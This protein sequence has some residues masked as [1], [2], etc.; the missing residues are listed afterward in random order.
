MK[1]IVTIQ[2]ISCIGKCSLTVALPILSAM[3]LETAILPTA[4]LS[5]HTMFQN[6]AFIDLTEQMT[7]ITDHWAKEGFDFE[8][9]YTGY[10]ASARQVELVCAFLERFRKKN[11]LVFV[12]PVMGDNGRLYAGFDPSF[13]GKMKLLCSKA[14]LIVPNLTEAALLTGS[15]YQEHPD[16]AWLRELLDEL[17]PLGPRYIV[18]TG[19][20]P[21]PDRIGVLGRDCSTGSTFSY[22]TEKLP[23]S[24]HGTGDIFASTLLG[25]LENDLNLFDALKT[26]CDYV[27]DTVQ[28]TIDNPVSRRYGVDFETTLPS[29]MRTMESCHSAQK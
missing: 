1:R 23:A 4:V 21:T 29:L 28:A 9:I 14:D 20:S 3:G 8:A 27:K 7:S 15:P 11:T 12:D 5:T 13:A 22:D 6:P 25:G 19:Y 24:Y 2:D 17:S 16:E 26:A 18:L 10:L